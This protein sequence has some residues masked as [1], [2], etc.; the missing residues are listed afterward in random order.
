MLN[1][2]IV[3]ILTLAFYGWI[4]YEVGWPR[5]VRS[6]LGLG[7]T[8]LVDEALILLPFLLA[9][10]LVLWGFFAAERALRPWRR[11]SSR[12]ACAATWC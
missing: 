3:M 7:D 1:R 6:G 8:I 4:I 9:Q 10:G 12:S 2:R 11:R 5:V